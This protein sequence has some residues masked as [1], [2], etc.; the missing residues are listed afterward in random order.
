MLG[1]AL[2]FLGSGW[3][4]VR[5]KRIPA[6]AGLVGDYRVNWMALAPLSSTKPLRHIRQHQIPTIM[7]KTG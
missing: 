7:N 4:R 2:T 1:A 3:K 6:M 5:K